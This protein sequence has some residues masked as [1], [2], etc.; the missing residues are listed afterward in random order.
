M[1]ACTYIY[2]YTHTFL[3]AKLCRHICTDAYMCMYIYIYIERERDIIIY[4]YIYI[5]IIYIYI[6]IS[7]SFWNRGPPHRRPIPDRVFIGAGGRG[8]GAQNAQ[9]TT[10]LHV[11]ISYKYASRLQVDVISFS[12]PLP[13]SPCRA[14]SRS[15]A[16]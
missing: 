14:R 6:Y 3:F 2:I 11:R 10:R 12:H 8:G 9:C 1:Y 15:G 16:V 7:L 13:S 4:T 5:H